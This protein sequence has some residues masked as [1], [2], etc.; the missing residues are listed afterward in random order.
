MVKAFVFGK[1]FPFHKGHEALI[2]FASGKSDFLTILICC[3]EKESIPCSKRRSWIEKTFARNSNIEVKTFN[4]S[5]SNLANTS[6]SSPEI[7]KA[8]SEIFKKLFPDYELLITSEPYGR[9]VASYMGIKYID[10]DKNRDLFPVSS[11]DIRSDPFGKWE[12][13]PDSVKPDFALKVVLLGTESTG[14]TTLTEKLAE[15]FRCS[16]VLEAGRDLIPDSNAFKFEDLYLVAREHA[17]RINQAVTGQSHLVIIDTDIHITQSYAKHIFGKELNVEDATYDSN[18]A[19]LYLYLKNDAEYV[20]DG[21]RLNLEQRNLLDVSHRE[22]LRN[23]NIDLIKI[24]G[25][26]Q[27]RFEQATEAIKK[28]LNTGK[29]GFIFRNKSGNN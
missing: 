27:Q 29:N 10:F 12:F 9:Y 15:Y 4:Y 25:S 28:L 11:T 18:K 8:W 5:E 21:T 17:R 26:W 23:H 24:T 20:Q 6:E 1:F 13:L 2:N 14:K 3:S 7:S 19:D 16:F 22:I